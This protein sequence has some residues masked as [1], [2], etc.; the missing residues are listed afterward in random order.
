MRFVLAAAVDRCREWQNAGNSLRFLV[1]L[2]SRDLQDE[3]VPYYIQQLLKE[4]GISSD[5]L[6]LEITENTVMQQLQRAIAV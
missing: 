6:T 5:R 4:H 2:S 3:Y 1:N